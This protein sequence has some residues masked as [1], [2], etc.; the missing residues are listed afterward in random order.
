MLKP[1]DYEIR[2]NR[3]YEFQINS[4]F[5]HNGKLMQQTITVNLDLIDLNDNSPTFSEDN[6]TIVVPLTKNIPANTELGQIIVEDLDTLNENLTLNINSDLF[7]IIPDLH[8]TTEMQTISSFKL[9]NLVE[10]EMDTAYPKFQFQL[11]VNDSSSNIDVADLSINIIKE[12]LPYI[13][14]IDNEE[15]ENIR[16]QNSEVKIFK[17]A[18]KI[19]KY[20]VKFHSNS[21]PEKDLLLVIE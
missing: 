18:D 19:W 4:R 12:D 13:N 6:Y 14:W 5:E 11:E 1:L 21:D 16:L 2:S 15:A 7:S 8:V 10:L 9:I 17:E 20:V 3:V